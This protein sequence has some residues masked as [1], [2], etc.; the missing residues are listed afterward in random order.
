MMAQFGQFLQLMQGRNPQ[1]L[2]NNLLSSGKVPKET[3]EQAQ[4]M[5]RQ[6]MPMLSNFFK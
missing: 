1:Q 4:Q 5:T 2:L 3:Y 6:F